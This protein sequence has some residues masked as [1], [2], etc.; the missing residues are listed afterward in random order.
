MKLLELLAPA[1][2][3]DSAI[4]AIDYGADAIYIGAASFGARQSAGNST[5]EIA[6]AVEYAHRFGAKVHATLN[7]VIY[8][9]ELKAAER[10]ACEVIDAG[11]DALIV[12]DMSFTRMK[13]PIELHASTQTSN[14]S[15]KYIKFLQDVG[16]KRVVLER[17][18]TIE[19]IKAISKA[20]PD[21][22][23][24][25]FVHGAICVGISGKCYLSRYLTPRS[26]NRG[27]CS[28]AC[29]LSYDL[30]GESGQTLIKNKHLLSVKDL[31]L[32]QHLDSLIDAGITSFKIEGRLKEINYTKNIVAYYRGL[33]DRAIASRDPKLFA[34]ASEGVS[35]FDFTADPAK[36]FSRDNCSYLIN[37]Q[38]DNLA[39]FNT[40]KAIGELI[41]TVS[42]ATKTGIVLD[43]K[44]EVVAGDGLCYL[45][46]GE[47]L[48]TNVNSS[49]GR[50]LILN[51]FNG[52]KVGTPIYRNFDKSFNQALSRNELR[53][54]IEIDAHLTITRIRLTLKYIDRYGNTAVQSVSGEF[55]PANNPEN[56]REIICRQIAKCG[57]SE[58]ECHEVEI[59]GQPLF[60]P[61]SMLAALRRQALIVLR[62]T[63]AKALKK[64]RQQNIAP[65]KEGKDA[66]LPITI[67]NGEW[68]VTNGSARQFYSDH[69]AKKI[70]DGWDIAPTLKGARLLQSRY[71]LRQEIG[72]CLKKGSQLREELFIVRGNCSFRLEFDC[73]TCQMNIYEK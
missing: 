48:G 8:D 58:F 9:S 51:R 71:C 47:L 3:A 55:S 68:N 14:T 33:L 43:S 49:E 45:S 16:F 61:S 37:G 32:S 44:K 52:I 28:Q 11:V 73:K 5:K 59:K 4:A 70:A 67:L 20:A 72:K 69:G 34:R 39:S 6:R 41:G 25:A 54:N 29:R 27:E 21:I 65:F 13:L 10:T 56:M 50:T 66:K 57:D 19:Q 7:T 35:R 46:N 60:V 42:R 23:L 24:E 26:G 36:S 2:N 63:R 40:P 17:A 31:N 12:Q 64:R 38:R 15:P 22:E 62:A 53:R 30:V 1:R 18:L